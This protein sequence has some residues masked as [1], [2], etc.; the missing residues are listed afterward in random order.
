M[1]VDSFHTFVLADAGI[2][3]ITQKLYPTTI[4]QGASFPTAS[5]TLD[6]DDVDDLLDGV[7]ALRRALISVD[8]YSPSHFEAEQLADAFETALIGY[9]GAFGSKTAEFITLARRFNLFESDTKL[10]RV[11]LQFQI[12][13]F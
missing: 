3:A 5:Y 8:C 13:Y 12:A 1:I 9:R 2:S 6:A 10:Y 4:V 11:S 7:G